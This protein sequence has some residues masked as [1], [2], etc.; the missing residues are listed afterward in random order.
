MENVS[1]HSLSESTG[2]IV[3]EK[4]LQRETGKL[5]ACLQSWKEKPFSIYL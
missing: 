4:M 5:Q 1:N 3:Q 2:I